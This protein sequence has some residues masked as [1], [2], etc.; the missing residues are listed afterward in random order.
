MAKETIELL[1]KT[2]SDAELAEN[3]A[4]TKATEII[5]NARKQSKIDSENKIAQ[6]KNTAEKLLAEAN[7]KIDSQSAQSNEVM[8]NN[9][10]ALKDTALKNMD[11]AVNAVVRTLL[12]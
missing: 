2:E 1:K 4:K 9:L 3:L 11:D 8:Q 12:D 6:A 10:S 5:E 7:M